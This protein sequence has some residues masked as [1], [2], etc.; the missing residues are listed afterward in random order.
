MEI[1]KDGRIRTE[2]REEVKDVAE[3]WE[4]VGGK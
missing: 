3:R 2:A 4:E 1:M